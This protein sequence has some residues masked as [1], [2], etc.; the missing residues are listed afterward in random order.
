MD[1]LNYF[2]AIICIVI[3][4]ATSFVTLSA[5]AVSQRKLVLFLAL[6]IIF[7]SIEQCLVFF[8]DYLTQNLS[9]QAERFHQMEDPFLRVFTGAAIYQSLW[10]AFCEFFDEK[11]KLLRY[12][13]VLIFFIISLTLL[14]VLP[15]EE[16]YKKWTLYSVRQFFLFWMIAYSTARYLTTDSPVTRVRYKQKSLLFFVFAFLAVFTFIEDTLIMLILD[17]NM[18]II[19]EA[20]YYIFS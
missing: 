12:L 10:L 18:I 4:V 11:R 14:F 3:C 17:P 6:F 13:P 2:L 20:L 1:A 8:N 19:D 16:S 5:F 9:F 7:Y 15:L